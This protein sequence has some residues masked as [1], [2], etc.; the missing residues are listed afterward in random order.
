[1][2]PPP[3]PHACFWEQAL[4]TLFTGEYTQVVSG[5][6]LDK[7]NNPLRK[8]ASELVVSLLHE[9]SRR[10]WASTWR[11]WSCKQADRIQRATDV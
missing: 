4:R 9:K 8:I 3:A 2:P 6:K 10:C 1:M 5:R 7:I 11:R